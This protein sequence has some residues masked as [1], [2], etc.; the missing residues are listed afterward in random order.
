MQAKRVGSYVLWLA[1]SPEIISRRIIG[2]TYTRGSV[3][4]VQNVHADLR[5]R[6]DQFS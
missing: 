5:R 6:G 3:R 4:P 1:C 2:Q